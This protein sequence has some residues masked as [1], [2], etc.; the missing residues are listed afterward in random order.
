MAEQHRALVTG[1]SRGIGRAVALRLAREGHAVAGCHSTASA[2]ARQ[3]EADVRMLGVPCYFAECDVSDPDRVEEFIRAAEEQLGPIDLLVNNAGITRD[4]PLALASYQDWNAVLATNLTGTWNLC[5]A[6]TFR[7]MKSRGGAVV[8]ISSVA[9]VYGN[10]G[11]T[12]YSASKA[13]IIGFSKSLAKEVAQYGIRVNVVAP[14]F[15]ETDMTESLSRKLRE[16][17]LTKI[18]VRRFGRPE[19]VAEL[20]AFLLSE[21]ASYITGQVIQVDGGITL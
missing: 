4:M 6:M 15:I 7:F 8:N 11:Q 2:A 1:S 10:A 14:G 13:G 16:Q 17:A 18:P 12:A 9:G 21:R 5:R 19:D 20:V 3:T